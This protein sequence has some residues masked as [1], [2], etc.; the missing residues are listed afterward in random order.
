MNTNDN[1]SGRVEQLP[2]CAPAFKLQEYDAGEL[3]SKNS[4]N[5][6]CKNYPYTQWCGLEA[7]APG[8][9][10]SI[11][12]WIESA[13]LLFSAPV[14]YFSAM[15]LLTSSLHLFPPRAILSSSV[16]FHSVAFG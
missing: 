1:G 2:Q 8:T 13:L 14:C 12:A 3:A 11:S 10:G 4:K 5:Y 6:K 7:Y 15:I 9:K 16:M